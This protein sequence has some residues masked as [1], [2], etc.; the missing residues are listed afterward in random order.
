[1]QVLQPVGLWTQLA[2]A[3]F[4]ISGLFGDILLIRL[5][6]CAAYA[7]L[8]LAAATGYPTWPRV[9]RPGF[10]SVDG[11]AWASVNLF[12]HGW[13]LARLLHDER[14][15]EFRDPEA[16]ALWRFFYRRSGMGRLEFSQSYKLARV[17]RYRAGERVMCSR[18]SR[19]RLG[20]LVEGTAHFRLHDP[21]GKV[22][23]RGSTLLF[24]GCTFDAA[25]LSVL[26]VF[27]GL[28][29]AADV[30]FTVTTDTDCT[31]VFW[32]L[33]DLTAIA[34]R[35]GPAVAAFWR[36]FTICQAGLQWTFREHPGLP[37]LNA[38]GTRDPPGVL[39]GKRL[40]GPSSLGSCCCRRSCR[41]AD[42]TEELE[43]HELPPRRTLLGTLRW[44]RSRFHPLLPPGVRHNALPITGA[45]AR[46]RLLAMAQ[47]GAC[48]QDPSV[49]S[50]DDRELLR[51][52]HSPACTTPLG[53][54]RAGGPEGGAG[55]G[56]AAASPA[57]RAAA[58][59]LA[60]GRGARA[61]RLGSADSGA[62]P[63][64]EAAGDCSVSG[65]WAAMPGSISLTAL[66]GIGPE[67]QRWTHPEGSS[68]G[69]PSSAS[70]LASTRPGSPLPPAD[71]AGGTAPPVLQYGWPG[72]AVTPGHS[73]PAEV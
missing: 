59:L 16:E 9:S 63:A 45:L 27:L 26:G 35:L 64:A 60:L 72:T 14:R 34:T 48:M 7:W 12:F 5:F 62:V 21:E 54:P 19:R 50:E 11:I 3:C 22:E 6:L 44:L 53:S 58:A 4:V 30:R 1:M 32:E 23:T 73:P 52:M 68:R 39:D 2:N 49:V 51:A 29:K 70:T 42:F 71:G 25:L 69:A 55:W 15:V 61:S 38:R 20:L 66:A 65:R 17:E 37:P 56:A 24:S 31:V 8:L 41:S 57:L 36:N 10:L 47:Y 28:E 18:A 43:P 13:N 67:P 46:N 40:A 33:A